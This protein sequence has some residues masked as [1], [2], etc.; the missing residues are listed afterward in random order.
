[1]TTS[2]V[3]IIGEGQITVPKALRDK[4]GHQAGTKF[5][6][7]TVGNGYFLEPQEDGRSPA[8]DIE[9]GFMEISRNLANQGVT[10]EDMLAELRRIRQRD[11]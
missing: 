10:L 1:M 8:S 4:N 3:E 2:A 11:E 6:V 7:V 5:D 9:A